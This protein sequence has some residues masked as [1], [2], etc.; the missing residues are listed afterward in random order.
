MRM[1]SYFFEVQIEIQLKLLHSK[2]RVIGFDEVCFIPGT[3]IH[4]YASIYS[5]PEMELVHNMIRIGGSLDWL[6]K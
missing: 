3:L 4:F 5:M 6:K 1:I 2:S